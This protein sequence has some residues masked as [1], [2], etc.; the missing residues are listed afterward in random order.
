MINS[1]IG[2]V[3]SLGEGRGG[4]Q[5]GRVTQENQYLKFCLFLKLGVEHMDVYYIILYSFTCLKYCKRPKKNSAT[6]IH[7]VLCSS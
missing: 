3:V 6:Y 1:K 5:L 7:Y 4:V 2:K